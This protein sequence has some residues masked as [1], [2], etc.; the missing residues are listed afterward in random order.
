MIQ[1]MDIMLH[2]HQDHSTGVHSSLENIT[3]QLENIETRLTFNNLINP[4]EDKA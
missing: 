4:D 2:L 3:T 1:K